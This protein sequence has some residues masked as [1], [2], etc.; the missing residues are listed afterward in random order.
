MTDGVIPVFKEKGYTSFD[1]VAKLRGILG[2][3]KIGHTGTLDPM[4]TG[5][6]PVC[7][8]KATKLVEHLTGSSKEY[9][10]VMQL[11]LTTDTLDI[12][13]SIT[14]K[15]EVDCD[16]AEVERAVYS[17][18]GSYM[19]LPPMYS[20]IKINGKR[21]YELAR[22]GRTAERRP[23]LCHI[24]YIE[25]TGINMPYASIRV[26]CSKGT[27]IRSL[28]DDIGSWLGCGAVMTELIRTRTSGF[29]IEDCYSLEEIEEEVRTVGGRTALNETVPGFLK[30]IAE[31]F[32][33]APALC[34]NAAGERLVKNGVRLR[35]TELSDLICGAE[36]AD[37]E[38]NEFIKMCSS[39]G[40]LIAVYRLDMNALLYR[41]YIMC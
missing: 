26:G 23:R 37:I 24:H 10:A 27:Y 33:E 17:F 15:R 30:G 11:G 2:I 41:L 21:L 34:L 19:Q 22:E 35:S 31:V 36:N 6:L 32:S 20:A 14:S 4:A 13:G 5:V 40:R 18:E 16:E 28:I 1:V 39:D 12:T 29:G 7:V 38:G 8:G 25:L 9:C 3:K